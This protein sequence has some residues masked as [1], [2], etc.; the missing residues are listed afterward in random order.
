M[1]TGMDYEA[2]GSE[3]AGPDEV[4]GGVEPVH[5]DIESP[6]VRA[7]QRPTRQPDH[8]HLGAVNGN[9]SRPTKGTLVP[10]ATATGV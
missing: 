1:G 7:W 6:R 4:P 2:W 10:T 9:P 5:E 8:K 3:L